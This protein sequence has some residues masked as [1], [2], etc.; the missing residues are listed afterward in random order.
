M[1]SCALVFLPP[2][3]SLGDTENKNNINVIIIKENLYLNMDVAHFESKAFVT[4]L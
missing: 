3:V 4:H 2:V 1:R